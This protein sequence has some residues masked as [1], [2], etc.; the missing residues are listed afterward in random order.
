MVFQN[1]RIFN[2]KVTYDDLKTQSPYNTYLNLGLPPTPICNSGKF[3][4]KA[5]L[6]PIKSDDIYFVADNSGKHVFA[7]NYKQHL[8]N[9]RNIRKNNK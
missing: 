5:V 9:I 7:S 1:G 8:K 3:S 6:N 2:R 4:I